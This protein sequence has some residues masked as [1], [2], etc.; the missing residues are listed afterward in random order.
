MV[1]FSTMCFIPDEF[2]TPLS[3]PPSE[4]EPTEV[5]SLTQLSETEIYDKLYD[6]YLECKIPV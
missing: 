3:T 2:Q 5:P 6:R 1:I 4:A